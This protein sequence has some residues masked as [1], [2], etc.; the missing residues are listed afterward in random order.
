MRSSW[1]ED[2]ADPDFAANAIVPEDHF[3][4]HSS[5]YT[6]PPCD[7]YDPGQT[8]FASAAE[9]R[10][11][12]DYDHQVHDQLLG[13]GEPRRSIERD[14]PRIVDYGKAKAAKQFVTK[15]IPPPRPHA[16]VAGSECCLVA[17][18]RR[19]WRV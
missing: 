18:R 17:C 9:V 14:R 4:P 5:I 1:E 13:S 6:D 3:D 7:T 10:V 2:F 19:W 12:S 15:A 8:Y 11:T 16:G